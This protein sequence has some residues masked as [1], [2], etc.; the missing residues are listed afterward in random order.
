MAGIFKRVHPSGAVRWRVAFKHRGLPT[1]S[2]SFEV[3]EEAIEW[4]KENE[5][6]YIHNPEKYHKFREDTRE[7]LK[8]RYK[9]FRKRK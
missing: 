4:A 5:E 7:L 6:K 3:L 2:R 8:Q 9:K 1:F